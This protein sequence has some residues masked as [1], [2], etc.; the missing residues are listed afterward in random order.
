M[1]VILSKSHAAN[2]LSLEYYQNSDYSLKEKSSFYLDDYD[3][4]ITYH[5]F[6]NSKDGCLTMTSEDECIANIT[7]TFPAHVDL[8]GDCVQI[9]SA[10]VKREYRQMFIG[11]TG[12]LS[13]LDTY[14]IV[15]DTEQTEIGVHLWRSKLARMTEVEINI[16]KDL[17]TEFPTIVQDADGND[18]VYQYEK[19]GNNPLD[20]EIWGYEDPDPRMISSV[21]SP[22]I[23]ASMDETR[24][25][26]VL[27]AK[28]NKF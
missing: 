4:T 23:N 3:L 13:L 12:Y 25:D 2:L 1:P 8:I 19:N 17:N 16:V 15:S 6:V 26:V 22:K 5:L 9:E 24:R 7:F 18:V 27:L 11:P 21:I 14:N 10:F 20:P 28:K